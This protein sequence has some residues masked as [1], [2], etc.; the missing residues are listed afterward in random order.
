MRKQVKTDQTAESLSGNITQ[1]QKGFDDYFRHFLY[2]Q[3][4]SFEYGEF[5]DPLYNDFEEFASRRAKRI[6]PL[7]FLISYQLFNTQSPPRTVPEMIRDE[8]LMQVAT[9]LELLHAFILIHDDVIDRSEMRRK[10]PTYHKLVEERLG[11]FTG[12]IRTG[13]N[14]AIVVGDMVYSLAIQTLLRTNFRSDL[15]EKTLLKFLEYANDTGAGEVLDILLGGKD[16]AHVTEE[17]IIHTYHLKTTRYTFECPLIIG[18]TLAGAEQG[19]LDTIRRLADPLGLAFQIEND[20]L[21]FESGEKAIQHDLIENKKTLL[22]R[23]AYDLAG[24]AERN[25]MQSC[26]D[27]PM[28]TD[29]MLFRLHELILETGAFHQLRGEVGGL[30]ARAYTALDESPLN[31]CQKY[32]LREFFSHLKLLTATKSGSRKARSQDE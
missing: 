13:Q 4:Q 30:F 2:V 9:A 15:K 6:R 20:L 14:V 12:R 1:I 26:F 19:V 17:E 29:A 28:L 7:L 22:L 3:R 10:L 8:N 27:S 21:E 32:V 24:N 25:F 23:R 11:H 5:F 31:D 18:A 16:V